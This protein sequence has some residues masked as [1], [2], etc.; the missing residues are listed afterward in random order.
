MDAVQDIYCMCKAVFC[1][2]IIYTYASPLTCVHCATVQYLQF[3]TTANIFSSEQCSKNRCCNF[4]KML[5]FSV[6][7]SFPPLSAARLTLHQIH[8]RTDPCCPFG[9]S[10]QDPTPGQGRPSHTVIWRHGPLPISL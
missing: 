8:K 1:T 6:T 5:H 9:L 2:C 4:S 7:A 3:Q 10:L